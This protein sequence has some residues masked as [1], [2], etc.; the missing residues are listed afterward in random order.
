MT[1]P[2]IEDY[3]TYEESEF[4]GLWQGVVGAW[5]P[6]LGPT[7][8]R[9][10]DF[11]RGNNWGT[12]TNMDPPTDWVVSNA[13]GHGIYAIDLDGSNDHVTTTLSL[14]ARTVLGMSLWCW[15]SSSTHNMF[16]GAPSFGANGPRRANIFLFGTDLYMTA[17][18]DTSGSAFIVTGSVTNTGWLHIFYRFNG[19]ASSR[20]QSFLN[21][22]ALTFSTTGALATTLGTVTNLEIGRTT[23][24]AG[25]SIFGTGRV[26]EAVAWGRDL[27]PGEIAQLHQ[28]GPGGIFQRRK[29]RY[30][31]AAEAAPA[32]RASWTTRSRTMIGGGVR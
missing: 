25:E 13:N 18:T 16:L 10:H 8:L 32:F 19:L 9:L 21:G 6:C 24:G 1:R 27:T 20:L 22:R 17:E 3:A 5:A 15:R 23:G 29:R 7:G 2:T 28:L 30:S 11:S 14:S 12:L 31:I 26:A 4:P